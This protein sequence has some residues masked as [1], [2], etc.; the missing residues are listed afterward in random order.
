MS[1]AQ[2][3]AMRVERE[4]WKLIKAFDDAGVSNGAD[5]QV[6]YAALIMMMTS[7]CKSSPAPVEAILSDFNQRVGGAALATPEARQ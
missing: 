3:E 6:Q 4:A 2:Q 1:D 7:F 5:R